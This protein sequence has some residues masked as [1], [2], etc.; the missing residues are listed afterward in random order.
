ME[1]YKD[2]TFEA[3]HLLP[4]VPTDHKCRQLHGHSFKVRL[5]LNGPIDK[6]LG[7]VEDFSEIKEVFDPIY[8]QL[9]HHYLNEIEGLE[10]PTSENLAKW[11]W[12]RLKPQLQSLISI[13]VKE[14][15]STGCIYRGE[16]G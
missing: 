3:A 2:I 14:T 7:W 10:N 11:I 1:I 8:N 4:N 16:D 15:C 12:N 5:T 13:E 6:S 9:D